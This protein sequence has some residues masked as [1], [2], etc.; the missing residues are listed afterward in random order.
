[1]KWWIRWL[2]G[3]EWEQKYAYQPSLGKPHLRLQ[4]APYLP[5]L[6]RFTDWPHTPPTT[7]HPSEYFYCQVDTNSAEYIFYSPLKPFCNDVCK[8]VEK[9]GIVSQEDLLA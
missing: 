2:E 8:V 5:H 3:G 9:E 4:L 7:L 1:M 6:H